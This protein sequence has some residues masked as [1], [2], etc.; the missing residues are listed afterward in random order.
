[1]QSIQASQNGAGIKKR[2]AT[3]PPHDSQ[4]R[5]KSKRGEE[6]DGEEEKSETNG[7]ASYEEGHVTG[8]DEDDIDETVG[9]EPEQ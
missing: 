5:R 3:G 2:K 1:M 8:T 6:T 9:R 4:S 7:N